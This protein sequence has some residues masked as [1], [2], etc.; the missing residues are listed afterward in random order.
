MI[1]EMS[2]FFNVPQPGGRSERNLFPHAQRL[3]GRCG[4][5]YAMIIADFA[6]EFNTTEIEVPAFF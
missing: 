4:G 5:S 3:P 1:F 6:T 2:D